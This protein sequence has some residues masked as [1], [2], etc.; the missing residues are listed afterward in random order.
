M[1]RYRFVLDGPKDLELADACGAAVVG[2]PV[3]PEVS[4]V[5]AVTASALPSLIERAAYHGWK[6]VEELPDESSEG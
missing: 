6:F 5:W 4:K 2:E 3:S 1:P